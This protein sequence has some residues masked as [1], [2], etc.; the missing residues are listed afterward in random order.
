M[1]QI[2]IVIGWA[3]LL[4]LL[5]IIWAEVQKLEK[6]VRENK[7]ELLRSSLGGRGGRDYKSFQEENDWNQENEAEQTG[8]VEQKRKTLASSLNESEEQIL[9]EVLTEFLG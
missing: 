4:V 7:R 3:M 8:Q 1:F 2:F 9:R 5:L 6:A